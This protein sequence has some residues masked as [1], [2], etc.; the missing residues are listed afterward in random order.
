MLMIGLGVLI[1]V[2]AA[3]WAVAFQMGQ[4]KRDN[5][6][7]QWQPPDPNG[8]TPAGN[9]ESPA[10]KPP[11]PVPNKPDGSGNSP[12]KPDP[13]KP[14]PAP[15]AGGDPRVPNFNYLYLG[16]LTLKDAAAGVDFLKR[17]GV[18]AFHVVDRSR[19]GGNNPPCRIYASQGFPGGPRF[20]ETEAER[21][22]LIKRVEELGKKWQREEKGASDF[23]QPYW[24]L[25]K[26]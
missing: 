5:E 1:V 12:K 23:R 3:V 22:E 10:P 24:T 9:G 14:E 13:V 19:G 15:A 4:Q 11:A 6:I 16:T 17:N 21:N 26:E 20:K 25:H 7:S 18:Q 8:T 2:I